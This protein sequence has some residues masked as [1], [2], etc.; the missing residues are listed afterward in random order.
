MVKKKT[1]KKQATPKENDDEDDQLTD[2]DLKMFKLL[3]VGEGDFT[4]R[5]L[6]KGQ[7]RLNGRLLLANQEILAVLEDL[8]NR[9]DA[10]APGASNQGKRRANNSF[11]DSLKRIADH[12]KYVGGDEPPGCQL[13][14]GGH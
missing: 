9:I 8:S 12:L 14:V 7:R 5:M 1:S 3:R 4:L 13:P 10:V 11:S 6:I 2:E